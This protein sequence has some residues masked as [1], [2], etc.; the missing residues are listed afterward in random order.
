MVPRSGCTRRRTT[1]RFRVVHHFGVRSGEPGALLVGEADAVLDGH[2]RVVAQSPS[3]RPG[4]GADELLG[5]VLHPV[6]AHRSRAGRRE[7]FGAVAMLTPLSTCTSRAGPC[8]RWCAPWYAPRLE[9]AHRALAA[10]T[11]VGD[12]VATAGAADR[13][14][15]EHVA[16]SSQPVG[17]RDRVVVGERD[18]R[19]RRCRD[20]GAQCLQ[21]ARLQDRDHADRQLAGR[22]PPR[23]PSRRRRPGRRRAPVEDA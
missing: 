17:W 12:Q 13:G 20:A 7:G 21:E 9:H 16:E 5:V 8:P 19:P 18:Q 6:A 11:L 15:R 3:P 14:F 23:A 22:T 2:A 10:L 1:R 4:P